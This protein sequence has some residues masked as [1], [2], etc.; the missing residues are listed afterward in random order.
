MIISHVC[1]IRMR[2]ES[3]HA[4]AQSRAVTLPCDKVVRQ[5]RRCDIGRTF[6]C[7][8]CPFLGLLKTLCLLSVLTYIHRCAYGPAIGGILQLVC[9]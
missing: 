1:L 7:L 4:I 8:H 9:H 6:L 3:Q 2:Q 5:N